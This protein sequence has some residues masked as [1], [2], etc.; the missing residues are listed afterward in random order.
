MNNKLDPEKHPSDLIDRYQTVCA[1]FMAG[2]F[3]NGMKLA[4]PAFW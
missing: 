1:F 3:D 4:V 2:E